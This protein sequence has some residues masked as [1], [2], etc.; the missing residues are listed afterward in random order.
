M[1]N[2]EA[3][4]QKAMQEAM[5]AAQKAREA[6]AK[7]DAARETRK[8]SKKAVER[9][10]ERYVDARLLKGQLTPKLVRAYI[11]G[12]ER[13]MFS[14]LDLAYRLL[15]DPVYG[16]FRGPKGEFLYNGETYKNPRDIQLAI[17]GYLGEPPASVDYI[18]SFMRSVLTGE[19]AD[20]PY[21]MMWDL[22]GEQDSLAIPDEELTL[23]DQIQLRAVLGFDP[24]GES[25]PREG[26]KEILETEE[27]G[28][29]D[30][31]EA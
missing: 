9:T 31:P 25:S 6:K 5:E 2:L 30:S 19:Q 20:S 7:E 22:A 4:A 18:D 21:T 14:Y 16:L 27:Q 13:P 11:E 12:K 10:L 17:E 28:S 1:A 26:L 24:L 8:R 29:Q 23:E 3:I 15:S